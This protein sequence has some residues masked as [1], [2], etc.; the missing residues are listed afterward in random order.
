[1]RW[2]VEERRGSTDGP[3]NTKQTPTPKQSS[4]G[5]HSQEEN[6]DT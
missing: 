3:H 4:Q 1:M 6:V 2:Q 5:K